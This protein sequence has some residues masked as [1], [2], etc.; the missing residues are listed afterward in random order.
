MGTGAGAK[1]LWVSRQAGA[2]LPLFTRDRFTSSTDGFNNTDGF[3][4]L[5]VRM[6][7]NQPGNIIGY[8]VVPPFLPAMIPIKGTA[9]LHQGIRMGKISTFT[10]GVHIIIQGFLVFLTG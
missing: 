1:Y 8:G 2:I 10:I 5:P 6:S 3:D 9:G 4:G 7:G